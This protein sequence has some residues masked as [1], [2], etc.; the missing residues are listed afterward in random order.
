MRNNDKLP[1]GPYRFRNVR[2]A[3]GNKIKLLPASALSALL[4]LSVITA[5]GCTYMRMTEQSFRLSVANRFTPTQERTKY[6]SPE[7]CFLVYGNVACDNCR[8][9][10]ALAVVAASVRPP[11]NEIVDVYVMN[12][13]GYYRLYLPEGA[14]QLLVFADVNHDADFEQDELIGRYPGELVISA[15]GARPS[16]M[17]ISGADIL[18]KNVKPESAEFPV[19]ISASSRASRESSRSFPFG[20]LASPDDDLFDEDYGGLGI[21]KP[22]EFLEK[23]P[24]FFY[25]MEEY[26]PAKIPVIFVHG[27][28]GT[29]AD[30]GYFIER[31]DRERFQ[32]WFF[33][34]PAGESLEKIAELFYRIFLSGSS[35]NLKGDRL[36]ITAHSMGGLV[37]RE[38]LNRY[39]SRNGGKLS[40]LFI[41]LCTPFGGDD[42]ASTVDNAPIALP[43]WRDM[44][45][46][47]PFMQNLYRR[48]LTDRITYY[49]FF[50]YQNSGLRKYL[51]SN[52]DGVV[53][54]K[55]QLDY[56]AQNDARAVYGFFDTH[57]GILTS[58]SSFTAYSG[59]IAG[60]AAGGK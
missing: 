14:Y 3:L 9:G 32:P 36:V 52:M 21:Y 30:W 28:G 12:S 59:I 20:A 49:L 44:A 54:I 38:A 58:I 26:D 13:P 34:Y 18:V 41:S 25:A 1:S 24:Y 8:K 53:A 2:R 40:I 4:L 27:A 10:D 5:A 31:I 51:G 39:I 11:Q 45:S 42:A 16:D 35:I 6:T 15:E 48:R 33:Y 55:S 17:I 57:E 7:I 60:F 19:D 56:R 50:A 47:S 23:V 43:S 22:A 29:P 46:N 37:V